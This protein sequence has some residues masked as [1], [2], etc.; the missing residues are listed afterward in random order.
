M[1]Q[2]NY[3]DE[4][5]LRLQRDT[6]AATRAIDVGTGRRPESSCPRAATRSRST[7]A[8][9]RRIAG[10]GPGDRAD[11]VVRESL[12]DGTPADSATTAAG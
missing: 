12:R 11:A 4:E 9:G 10:R 8:R 2:R 1:L 5:L 3:R 6:V 7:T